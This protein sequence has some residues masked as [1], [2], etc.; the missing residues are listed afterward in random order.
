M[1]YIHAETDDFI[2]LRLFLYRERLS[3]D[4]G[5]LT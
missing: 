5:W 2:I 3:E 1:V 4:G